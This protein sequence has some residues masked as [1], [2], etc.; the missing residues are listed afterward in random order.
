MPKPVKSDFLGFRWEWA[1]MPLWTPA[2]GLRITSLEPY[3]H[4]HHQSWPLLSSCG[5]CFWTETLK[6]TKTWPFQLCHYYKLSASIPGG[7][8]SSGASSPR[9]WWSGW[10]WVDQWARPPTC[11][12][13]PQSQPVVP[14]GMWGC[15]IFKRSQKSAFLH[16][17]LSVF[18]CLQRIKHLWKPCAGHT[19][20]CLAKPTNTNSQR[21]SEHK[22]PECKGNWINICRRKHEQCLES[23]HFSNRR[24][25][26]LFA[27]L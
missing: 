4:P 1:L 18:K 13:D 24:D 5:G 21:L 6:V 8:V 27:Y 22:S 23:C 14:S 7:R 10:G 26:S 19:S 16:G 3:I 2:L 9:G 25:K 11:R 20:R 17:N 15:P 12:G